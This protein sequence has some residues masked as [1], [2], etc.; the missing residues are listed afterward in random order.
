M[1]TYKDIHVMGWVQLAPDSA[2]IR[3]ITPILEAK[4][5][6]ATDFWMGW[7]APTPAE[8]KVN[9]LARMVETIL[10]DDT[11]KPEA[12]Q[13]YLSQ[14]ALSGYVAGIMQ[15]IY[16][17]LFIGMSETD[18]EKMM[19]SFCLSQCHPHQALIEIVQKHLKA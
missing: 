9:E 15:P 12:N 4:R 7:I 2:Y 8:K 16:A 1:W 11:I 5:A 18:L 6:L 14:A 13:R 19:T 3:R 17:K 10:E